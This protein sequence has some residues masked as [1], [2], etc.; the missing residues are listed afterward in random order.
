V[1]PT[2]PDGS[3]ADPE[4]Q[5]SLTPVGDPAID[6]ADP[7]TPRLDL[8]HGYLVGDGLAP[9][10]FPVSQG[11]SFP[12]APK[13]GDFCL[14]LDYLP[15]RLFRYDGRRWQKVEDAVRT[16]YTPG[17]SGTLRNSFVN[18]TD[19]ITL[20]GRVVAQR[21]SLSSI[22]Q[23]RPAELAPAPGGSGGIVG[24]TGPRG[25]RGLSGP[26]GATGILKQWVTKSANYISSN[27][28]RILADTSAGAFTVFLPA[29]PILGDFVQITEG[30]SNFVTNNLILNAQGRT[31][32]NI[33]NDIAVDVKGVTLEIIYS[34]DTWQITANVGV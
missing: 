5:G 33:S 31:I 17:T 32:E 30:G 11:I 3:P 1:V 24:A 23:S 13:L 2:N 16:S 14:R 4:G 12:A 20:S 19:T 28:D 7:I 18:N 25:P 34:G 6:N 8:N 27:G 9:N 21:Q 26:A 29:D 15:N 22:L 10:G